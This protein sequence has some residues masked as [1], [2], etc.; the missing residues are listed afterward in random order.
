MK[1]IEDFVIGGNN[2]ENNEGGN[3]AIKT[4]ML[5]TAVAVL[6]VSSGC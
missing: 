5:L 4:L 1:K 3:R 2:I 6:S